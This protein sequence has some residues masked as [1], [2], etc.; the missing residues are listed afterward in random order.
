MRNDEGPWILGVSASHNG[1][2][3]LLKGDSIVVAVQEERLSRHKRHRVYGAEPALCVAYCL[4]YAGIDVGSLDVV[5]LGC[6]EPKDSVKNDMFLNPQLRLGLRGVPA[7]YVSH[8][9]AHALSAYATSGFNDSAILVVDG[10]G[11]PWQDLSHSEQS[12]VQSEERGGWE[13]ISL[14]SAAGNTI[15]PIAKHLVRDGKWLVNED[16]GMPR[17]GT[18]GGMYSAVAKQI[19]DNHMEAGKVMGLAAYGT[20]EIPASD[21]FVIQNDQFKFAGTVCERYQ[22]PVKWPHKAAEYKVLAA[23]TQAA[24]EDALIYLVSKLRDSCSSS[25]LCFTGGVALNSV[26][27]ERLVRESGYDQMHFFPAAEDSGVAV[28]A[29]FYGLLQLEG[30]LPKRRLAR[31]SFGR[32]YDQAAVLEA[33][34]RVPGVEVRPCKDPIE[35]TA[36]MLVDGKAVGW[37]E[38]GS[39]LGP[40]AL[41]QRSIL[42]DPRRPDGKDFLNERVKHREGFRPY[43]PACLAEYSSQWFDMSGQPESPFMMRT[44]KVSAAKRNMIPAVVHIDGT[45]RIQTLTKQHNGPFYDLVFRFYEKTGVPMVLNTSFNVAGEPL[46]ESPDDAVWCLLSTELDACIIEG[47]IIVKKNP[48]HR[49]LDLYPRLEPRRVNVATNLNDIAEN[50]DVSTG[51]KYLTVSCLTAWGEFEQ[52]F[53]WLVTR[54]LKRIDG[55]TNGRDILKAL[56]QE[57]VTLSEFELIRILLELGSAH[58]VSIAE[59]PSASGTQPAPAAD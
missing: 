16:A 29:A 11:S 13:S 43:A 26:A 8:H 34:A 42:F 28:G 53:P 7:L 19:F 40:R 37:F 31:D 17:F 55:V 1:A 2:A 57:K 58:L 21:F 24:L 38:G 36:E 51:D 33:V 32:T 12:T 48:S 45:A 5:V 14:Y 27:N 52:F 44:C 20:P 30:S 6:Q 41:G 25:N 46:V 50:G 4:D 54:V 15:T 10:M 56:S 22:E 49:L 59:T 23:S 9:L 18:L 3:C 35:C 39:E 47:T